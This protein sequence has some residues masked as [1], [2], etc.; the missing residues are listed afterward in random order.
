[1]GS[2]LSQLAGANLVPFAGG[3][4]DIVVTS[5][6]SSS[7]FSAGGPYGIHAPCERLKSSVKSPAILFDHKQ[8]CNHV[9]LDHT[10]SLFWAH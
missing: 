3:L 1:M 8:V 5:F 7:G 6:K 2:M 9:K 4:Y 10:C